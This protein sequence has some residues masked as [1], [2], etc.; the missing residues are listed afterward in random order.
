MFKST[1][2]VAKKYSVTNQAVQ[3]W[4]KEG[5]FDRVKKTKGG[6]YRIWID[7]EIQTILYARISNAEQKTSL[8]RQKE[9]LRKKYPAARLLSDIA[10]GS[11]QNRQGYKTFLEHAIKGDPLH[12]VATT[13][14]RITQT[15][16]PLIK[17]IIEL[18]GGRV[19]LLEE[20]DST[21]Q[22]DTKTLMA[23]ITSFINTDYEKRSRK[24]HQQK[25]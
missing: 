14:D 8:E 10:S 7:E 9:L 25:D 16:F 3:N 19:E 24:R 21:E 1:G 5:K 4:I 17:W 12:I 15:G 2:Y 18:S 20:T 11:N 22:L 13:S 23:F 6:H